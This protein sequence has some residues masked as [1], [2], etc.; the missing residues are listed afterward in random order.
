MILKN[1]ILTVTYHHCGFQETLIKDNVSASQ[2]LNRRRKRD[3]TSA[4]NEPLGVTLRDVS[5]DVLGFL[6]GICRDFRDFYGFIWYLYGIYM[7]S[8]WLYRNS[9][10][11]I[12]GI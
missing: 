6:C 3:K 5:L 7:V 12:I 11:I 2:E 10:G 4:E 9:N 8:I 1:T